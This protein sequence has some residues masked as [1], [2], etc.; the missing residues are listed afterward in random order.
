M[1]NPSWFWEAYPGCGRPWMIFGSPRYDFRSPF[2]IFENCLDSGKHLMIVGKRTWFL[3]TLPD[4]APLVAV[5]DGVVVAF[6]VVELFV[7]VCVSGSMGSWIVNGLWRQ[8]GLE[9]R[10]FVPQG[11]LNPFPFAHPVVGT[12]LATLWRPVRCCV[13]QIW[14]KVQWETKKK[15]VTTSPWW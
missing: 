11:L 5:G 12:Y 9:C 15:K 14:Q 3:E 7:L 4:S 10:W 6:V 1:G 13:C 2:L 8:R